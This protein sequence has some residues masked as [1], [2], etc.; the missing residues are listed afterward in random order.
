MDTVLTQSSGVPPSG[1][2]GNNVRVRAG[3]LH[4]HVAVSVSLL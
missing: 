1:T 4:E 3:C 2:D